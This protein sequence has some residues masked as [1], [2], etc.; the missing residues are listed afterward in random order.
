[1]LGLGFSPLYKPLFGK[2]RTKDLRAFS[3]KKASIALLFLL[4]LR[5]KSST[6][7][8][9]EAKREWG[10]LRPGGV[11]RPLALFMASL[12]VNLFLVGDRGS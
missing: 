3:P 10:P 1:M 9:G 5:T 11:A 12:W 6:F 4:V 2:E 7:S 8:S